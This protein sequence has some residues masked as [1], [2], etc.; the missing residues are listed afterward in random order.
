[1][2]APYV[3]YT[4]W[5]LSSAAEPVALTNSEWKDHALIAAFFG[6]SGFLDRKNAGVTLWIQ[7]H[8]FRAYNN[9]VP[10]ISNFYF[11]CGR[12]NLPGERR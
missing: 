11:L 6:N 8:L 1:M 3:F 7:R 10:T 12:A 5:R 2:I 9:E 4:P